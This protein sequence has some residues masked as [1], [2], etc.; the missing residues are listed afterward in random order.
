MLVSV[1]AEPH[2]T[3]ARFAES[4]G[5]CQ[6]PVQRHRL[7]ESKPFREYAV[8][9]F[10]PIRDGSVGF[11]PRGVEWWIIPGVCGFLGKLGLEQGQDLLRS[12]LGKRE[13]AQI[14]LGVGDHEQFGQA[15][16]LVAGVIGENV[17]CQ[18][19]F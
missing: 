3:I 8:C 14:R 10:D 13:K 7:T 19:M 1:G 5:G 16:G 17:G 18:L 2:G 9:F 15:L 6:K 4:Q 12:L 11:C